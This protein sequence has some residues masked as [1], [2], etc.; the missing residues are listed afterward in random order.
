M[1]AKH[2]KIK[3]QNSEVLA[4]D[5]LRRRAVFKANPEILVIEPTNRCNLK[6]RLCARN[7][8]DKHLNPSVDMSRETLELLDPF[9]KTANSVYAFGHGEPTL[10][11]NFEEI[12]RRAKAWGCEVQLTTNGTRLDEAFIDFIIESQVDIVNLSLDAVE[13][14]A[15]I[16]R[17]GVDS[18]QVL[19][20]L[21]RLWEKKT[22]VGSKTPETGFAFT[23]DRDNLGELP[24]MIDSLAA[25]GASV[26][27][28]SHFVAWAPEV[29]HLSSYHV[30]SEFHAAF[31][32]AAKKGKEKGITVILP[33][34]NLLDGCCPHPMTMFFVRSSGEVWPCCNAVFR[35]GQY[36]FP[37][38]NI[39]KTGLRDIWNSDVYQTL[40]RAWFNG[41]PPAHCRICPLA[42]DAL[43]SHLRNLARS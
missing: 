13:S 14:Q 21:H 16:R 38:G 8:W 39:H 43:D 1:S 9:L 17:R 34:D 10:G 3:S 23:A 40:R 30:E 28:I 42:T 4:D 11:K 12:I 29:H 24:N 26:L 2:D 32:E 6:C 20:W 36:S 37:A 22:A 15:S 33:F 5:I 41:D 25:V 35:Q 7:Y 31:N 19:R 27:I 18:V